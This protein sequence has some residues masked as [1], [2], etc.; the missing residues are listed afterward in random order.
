MTLSHFT[1]YIHAFINNKGNDI[2]ADGSRDISLNPQSQF[3]RS[4]EKPNSNVGVTDMNAYLIENK[5]LSES[6]VEV[7]GRDIEKQMDKVR[8][9]NQPRQAPKGKSR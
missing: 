1:K 8:K 9:D 7:K 6:R 5:S 4:R 2:V 3:K